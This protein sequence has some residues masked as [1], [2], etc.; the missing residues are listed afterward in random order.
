MLVVPITGKI[1]WKNPPVV[2]IA[3]IL[4]NCLI[5]FLFQMD[6]N[7]KY[8][9]AHEQYF[10]S[11]LADIEVSAY[12]EYKTSE[13]L[14]ADQIRNHF[15]DE[16]RNQYYEAMES[17][18][19]FQKKLA[20]EKII[21][22]N[23]PIFEK[24]KG[25]KLQ[26]Q[27]LLDDVTFLHYGFIPAK[28]DITTAF[29]YMFLHGGFTHLL[30]NMIFLWL[31]GCMLEMGC[32]RL[33]CLAAYLI[34]GLF[35]VLLFWAVYMDSMVPLVGASGAI[36]GFMGAFTTV[37]GRKKIK[38]FYSLGFYFNYIKFPAIILFPIWIGNEFFQLFS[39]EQSNVAYVAHIGGLLSGA[40]MGYLD[41]KFFKIHNAEVFTEE[42]KDEISPLLEHA[43][44]C[45]GRL[46]I[47]EARSYLMKILTKAPENKD[48]LVHLFNIEKLTPQTQEFHHAASRLLHFYCR[49]RE[50]HKKA[51]DIYREYRSLTASPRLSPDLYTRLGSVFS[52]IGETGLSEKIFQMLVQKK[53]LQPGIPE[54]LLKL[55][56]AEK[57]KGNL[58]K[59]KKCLTLVCT[60]YPESAEARIAKQLL[61]AP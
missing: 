44:Q 56:D 61:L 30:G 12:V 55:A 49:G 24:W 59:W 13:K 6:D 60:Q 20:A 25:L 36:A 39:I 27:K 43:L 8:L 41:L 26:N 48:A 2:T 38:V 57:N 1:S 42:P 28:A 34:T 35:S 10:K 53:P 51:Y 17:D 15:N 22:R 52:G 19:E 31:V 29:T 46:E 5:F 11:G 54:G 40:L 3:L 47:E 32:G 33:F 21:T 7:I 4:I 18:S 37:Y 45:I 14:P 23:D 16:I 58:A 50:N 9:L